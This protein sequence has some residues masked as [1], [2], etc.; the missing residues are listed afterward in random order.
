MTNPFRWVT[1]VDDFNTNYIRILDILLPCLDLKKGVTLNLHMDDSQVTH[2]YD[3]IL[4]YNI[5]SDLGT[6]LCFYNNTIRISGGVY[7]GCTAPMKTILKVNFKISYYLIKGK[8]FQ[9]KNSGI[10]NVLWMP[11][12]IHIAS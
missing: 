2:R 5:F 7:E 1:Q 12:S 4:G 11:H 10:A 6:D 8:I 9:N 3:I